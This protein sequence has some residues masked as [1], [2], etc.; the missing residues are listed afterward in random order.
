[1]QYEDLKRGE[2]K[3]RESKAEAEVASNR[4][5][6]KEVKIVLIVTEYLSLC[7]VSCHKQNSTFSISTPN[8]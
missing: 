3:R 6:A 2:E 7:F 8:Q 1:M 4:Y 5:E